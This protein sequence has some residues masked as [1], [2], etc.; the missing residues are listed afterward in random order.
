MFCSNNMKQFNL[1]ILVLISSL[2]FVCA[3]EKRQTKFAGALSRQIP[4]TDLRCNVTYTGPAGSKADSFKFYI[5]YKKDDVNGV[6][7]SQYAT[8]LEMPW[9]KE[10]IYDA[11]VEGENLVIKNKKTGDVVLQ[12]NLQALSPEVRHNLKAEQ[13]AAE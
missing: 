9:E 6:A 4:G 2:A 11:N 12:I 7:D 1:F 8:L 10:D 5:I 3:Q 13:G